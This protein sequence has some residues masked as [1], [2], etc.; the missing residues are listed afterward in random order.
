MENAVNIM[1]GSETPI[2]ANVMLEELTYN[3][4]FQNEK[5]SLHAQSI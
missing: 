1:W 5:T 2:T 3:L 4:D